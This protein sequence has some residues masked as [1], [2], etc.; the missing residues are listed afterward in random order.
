ME[1]T[2]PGRQA[3]RS[4]K[5]VQ[6]PE[7]STTRE[8]AANYAFLGSVASARNACRKLSTG[9][10][11][12]SPACRRASTAL[13]PAGTRKTS[14]PERLAPITFC[15]MPPIGA[16]P[17]SSSSSPV[18][19]TLRPR[20]TFAAQLLDDVEGE[21]E[22]CRR[23]AD[24]AEVDVD[25]DRELDVGEL[26]DLDADDRTALLLGA[27]DRADLDD[28]GRASRPD[29]QAHGLSRLV[30]RDQP[31]QVVRR[32]ARA[33]RRPRRSPRSAR[34]CPPAGASGAT[35]TT[36]APS[37]FGIDRRS[38]S[39]RSATAAATSS[40]RSIWRRFWRRRSADVRAR[41]H[42]RLARARD[43]LRR[44]GRR[45]RAPRAA[46]ALRTITST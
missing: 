15:L 36:S 21:R 44:A 10:M 12:R 46:L 9:M 18:A 23:A 26:L 29:A 2:S 5:T 7:L 11:R 41:W 34:A 25:A 39:S 38:P 37:G 3:P 22:P 19:A 6:F 40:E 8:I 35:A 30:L 33:C 45:R 32:A 27:L 42:E 1:A 31:A 13:S 28:A 43:P 20:S 4:R 16:T 14:A 17:P 24:A